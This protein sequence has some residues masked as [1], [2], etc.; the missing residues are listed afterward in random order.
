MR[1]V[2]FSEARTQFKQAQQGSMSG[3]ASYQSA[4]ST[5]RATPKP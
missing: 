4:L 5:Y 1:V 2:N 3:M